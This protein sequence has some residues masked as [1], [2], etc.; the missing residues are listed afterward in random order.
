MTTP[1]PKGAERRLLDYAHLAAYLSV[2]IRTAK[3]LAADGE[4][5]KVPLGHRVLFD[6]ADV[7]DYI[8][9]LKRTA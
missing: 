6:K 5:R 8:E 7:D 3:Q 2:S 9:R 1:P 4:I